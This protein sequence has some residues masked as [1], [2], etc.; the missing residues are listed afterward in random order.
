MDLVTIL[1]VVLG[2]ANG[3]RAA[4]KGYSFGLW[5]ALSAIAVIFLEQFATAITLMVIYRED[6]RADP[7]AMMDFNKLQSFLKDFEL[8]AEWPLRLLLVAISV[9]GY[10]LIRF[11]L[12]QIPE[13]TPRTKG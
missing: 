2:F 4:A 5:T 9:G 1:A 10:V 6:L 11:I 3:R 8:R 7:M 13:K 12:D